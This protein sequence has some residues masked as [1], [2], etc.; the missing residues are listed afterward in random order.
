MWMNVNKLCWSLTQL[1]MNYAF[2]YG[3]GAQVDAI[4][5]QKSTVIT[6]LY[7]V[8]FNV[9]PNFIEI[10]GMITGLLAAVV[11]IMQ[12][13]KPIQEEETKEQKEKTAAE[14]TKFVVNKMR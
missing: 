12:N 4:N 6:I 1:F 8:A 10:I 7:A 11:I 9:I 13:K 3:D 14:S 5:T 2:K